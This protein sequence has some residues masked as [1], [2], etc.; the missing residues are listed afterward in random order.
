MAHRLTPSVL[1]LS[2]LSFAL[3]A[4]FALSQDAAAQGRGKKPTPAPGVYTDAQATRG[5][6][7]YTDNCVYCHLVDLSG[8][9]LAPALTGA[10]FIAKWTSR[11][12]SDVF[13]Y[14]RIAM[15]MNSPGGLSAEQNAD[16]LAFLLRKSGFTPGATDLPAETSSLKSVVAPR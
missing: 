2:T 12:L 5:E 11:P 10:P 6:A 16:I 8:G 9:E 15:P 3:A 14:M 1:A 7:L 13:D 4:S